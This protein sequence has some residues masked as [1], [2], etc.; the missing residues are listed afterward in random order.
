MRSPFLKHTSMLFGGHRSAFNA[1][2]LYVIVLVSMLACTTKSAEQSTTEE[3]TQSIISKIKIKDLN[4][5]PIDLNQYKGKTI[6]INFWATWC[7]PCI[8]EMPSI[9]RAKNILRD[10]KIEFL[11]ASNESVE[12]I[13]SFVKKRDLSLHYV[14]LQNMEE[15]GIPALPTTYIFNPGGKLVFAET[16][17]REWDEA[18]NIDLL[19]KIIANHE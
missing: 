17:Y 4:D 2:V 8:K 9:E 15:L 1:F 14:Q 5:Q 13:Q 3:R 10:S 11:V 16:G 6:F 18:S 19:T 12:Q 7:G